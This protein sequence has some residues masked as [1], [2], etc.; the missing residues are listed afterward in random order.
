[1][2][3]RVDDASQAEDILQDV[4]VKAL[5]EGGHFCR[6]DS[7]RA[8]L[9]QVARHAVIDHHRLTKVTVPAE[10]TLAQPVTTR[11]P[12][13]AL[14]GG[15][16]QS[17][18]ALDPDDRDVILRCDIEGET[19]AAYASAHQLTLPAVKSRI[20]RARAR[21]RRQLVQDAAVRFDATG[22]VCCHGPFGQGD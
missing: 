6:L 10:E 9:Y 12:V 7:P 13:D 5:R 17:L 15:L 20:Q 11:R 14:A 22:Q 1:L 3:S 4:F 21:L 19:Q 2:L 8:W 18:D 16:G